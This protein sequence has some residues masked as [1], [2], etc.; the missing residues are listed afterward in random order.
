ML[1]PTSAVLSRLFPGFQVT[2]CVWLCAHA[3]CTCQNA[4]CLHHGCMALPTSSHVGSMIRGRKV[5][6]ELRTWVVFWVLCHNRGGTCGSPRMTTFANYTS[7]S[8]VCV[9]VGR[10]MQC[11]H[12]HACPH[13]RTRTHTRT[14]HMQTH[15][16]ARTH[17]Y[18]G[19]TQSVDTRSIYD[20]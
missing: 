1:T 14:V 3:Q 18:Y 6:Q 16:H 12:T 9:Q 17:T 20:Q 10:F 13:T 15:T 11:L 19:M 2:T 4:P 7:T 5:L 8:T